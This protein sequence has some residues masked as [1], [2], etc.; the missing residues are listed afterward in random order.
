MLGDAGTE[1]G[2]VR[3]L[4]DAV[5]ERVDQLSGRTA[6]RYPAD[7]DLG[8]RREP[9]YPGAVVT[10]CDQ[11][12]MVRS[13][14]D[15]V[16]LPAFLLIPSD[17][18]TTVFDPAGQVRMTGG[19]PG[20]DQRDPD[21]TTAVGG[22]QPPEAHDA[23]TPGVQRPIRE[24]RVGCGDAGA[25]EPHRG[26]FAEERPPHPYRPASARRVDL[27]RRWRGHHLGCEDDLSPA[28][29]PG[30]SRCRAAGAGHGHGRTFDRVQAVVDHLERHAVRHHWRC[31]RMAMADRVVRLD[32]DPRVG[33]QHGGVFR[34][35]LDDRD[36]GE[37]AGR[38]AP[39]QDAED[40][41][42]LVLL[43]LLGDRP[44]V[45]GRRR[46]D[47]I[48]IRPGTRPLA[49]EAAC[50]GAGRRRGAFAFV[51]RDSPVLARSSRGPD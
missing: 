22:R 32:V 10:S 36:A 19:D 50:P 20:V 25:Y 9:D 16:F 2:Y 12:G 40:T 33:R 35:H 4:L 1:H 46:R 15:E 43:E 5:V 51:A 27:D 8:V 28:V 44:D 17:Q 23:G 38:A 45:G 11:G 30:E 42:G 34:C 26:V 6:R 29:G 49:L 3:V 41:A 7:M 39:G 14:A 37:P 47:Q 48:A 13:G 31:H 24:L 18:V 21:A